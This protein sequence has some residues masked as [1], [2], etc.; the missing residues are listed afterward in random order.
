V[1]RRP[2][3]TDGID[4]ITAEQVR[5]LAVALLTEQLPLGLDGYKYTDADVHQVLVAAAAQARSVESVARQLVAAPSANRVRQVLA[6]H[7]FAD[8]DLDALEAECNALLAARLPSGLDRHRHRLAVDLVLIPY[9]GAPADEPGEIR[10]GAAKSGT[11]HF[12]C[13]ATAY[14]VR[15]GRRLTLALAFVRAEDALLDVLRDLLD[16]VAA[17]GVRVER[18]LL[19]RGFVSV[20]VLAWLQDQPVVSVVALPKRGRRLKALLIGKAG[21][22]TTYTMRSADDGEAT[23]PLWVAVS[24]AAGRRGKHGREYRPFAVLGQAPCTLSVPD[25]ADEYRSR[26]GIESSYRMAHQV[27]ARTTS[28]DPAL[29]LLLVTVACLLVNLWVYVKA[30][31]VAATPPRLRAAARRWLDAHFRLDG[32]TDLLLE[33]IKTRWRTRNTLPYPFPLTVPVKL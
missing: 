18:L 14:L 3:T 20:A 30:A 2:T 24:Y 9:H 19:D 7:L 33:A 15:A 22:R 27:R 16:R 21:Y 12:H 32:L 6:E 11:T 8:L 23:F 13:Y 29:R 5:A 31:L 10:R 1:A 4:A 25:L 26:F 17:L 28:R